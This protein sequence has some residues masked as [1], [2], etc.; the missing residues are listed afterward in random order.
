MAQDP[1][2]LREVFKEAYSL[3]YFDPDTKEDIAPDKPKAS[4]DDLLSYYNQR[5]HESLDRFKIKSALELLMICEVDIS[6]TG[7]SGHSDRSAH[8]NELLEG[9]DINSDM[10]KRLI[11][12]LYKHEYVL[13]DKA[14]VNL[15]GSLGFY[16]SA[17]F[18]YLNADKT[19]RAILFCDGL[20]HDRKEIREDDSHKRTILRERGMD[21]IEWY[22]SESIPD[23]VE[24]R[25]DIF[26]KA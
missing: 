11:E 6:G 4:Y 23:L 14:Q 25:K 15:S 26:R 10:E 9:Y 1:S 12:Y 21:V 19:I 7:N 3:M 8:Y 17:D 5:Y 13:P 16:V 2:K 24:R 22:Y 20:I 18:V